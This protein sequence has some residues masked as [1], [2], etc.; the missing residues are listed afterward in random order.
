MTDIFTAYGL[1]KAATK[2]GR[3]V[4]KVQG[5]KVRCAGRLKDGN[6]CTN[7]TDNPSG[8]CGKHYRQRG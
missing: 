2:V 4:K 1:Y 7:M 6:R 5:K 3:T 8:K